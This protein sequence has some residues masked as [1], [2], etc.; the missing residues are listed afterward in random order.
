MSALQVNNG[1]VRQGD[2]QSFDPIACG[3]EAKTAAA[4]SIGR[5]IT[6]QG[7]R[8]F[9]RVRR[10]EEAGLPDGFFQLVESHTRLDNGKL[11]LFIDI[12]DLVKLLC[13]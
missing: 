4:G 10:I 12:N 6:A 9:R 1:A 13:C 7:C 5:D 3:A 8:F 2:F 11:L